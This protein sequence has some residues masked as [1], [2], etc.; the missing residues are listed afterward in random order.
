MSVISVYRVFCGRDHTAAGSG[1]PV[2][3]P[4]RWQAAAVVSRPAGS[5]GRRTA[6]CSLI[7]KGD[8]AAGTTIAALLYVLSK[9]KLSDGVRR[10]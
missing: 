1:V 6:V 5:S 9:I 7:E 4:R 8:M 3:A 2:T 10:P